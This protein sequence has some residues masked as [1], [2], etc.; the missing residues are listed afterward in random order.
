MIEV[1]ESVTYEKFVAFKG[2]F[3]R[4]LRFEGLICG[5]IDESRAKNICDAINSSIEHF[6]LNS[7]DILQFR[8]MVKLPEK[9]VNNFEETNPLP[10]GENPQI[11]PN[12]AI[13]SYFQEGEKTYAKAGL[14]RVLFGLIKEPAFN[15]LRTN[16]QLGY[17]VSSS[18]N[19]H[20]KVLGGAISIQSSKHGADYLES[21]INA[22]LE[23]LPG[24]TEEQVENVKLAQIKNIK[25]VNMNIAQEGNNLWDCI[26]DDNFDFDSKDRLLEA[27]EN[28]TAE[29]VNSKMKDLLLYNQRRLNVKLHS[30][31][32]LADA[33]AVSEAQA[34]NKEFYKKYGISME[35]IED[36]K[37]F[38]LTSAK[39]PKRKNV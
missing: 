2:A 15:Q 33:E 7:D 37:V 9:S 26:Q 19:S 20:S 38:D 39:W 24:F 11:N 35:T 34:I 13:Q 18:F 25:Q 30:V 23:G 28:V 27:I 10:A 14:L 12:S 32:H 8:Q 21:R 4:N 3:M 6:P 36:V 1:L 31:N 16:E 5:H 17:I 22:F 29:Q